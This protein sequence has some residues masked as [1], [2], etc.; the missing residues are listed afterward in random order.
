MLVIMTILI[1][2]I[3]WKFSPDLPGYLELKNYKPSLTTRVFTSDGKLLD[4]YFIE[5]RLFV[6]IEK[7]PKNL[8]N[9]FI[10]A[11]DKNYYSHVGFDIFSIIGA[12]LTNLSNLGSN[13]R[14]IGA[15]TITQQ[16]VKNF[17]LSKEISLER[18]IKEV[19][20]AI[21]IEQV[22]SKDSILELYL[23]DIYLGY[24]SY[25]VAASSLNY[26]NKPLQELNLEEMAYLA[27]LPKAPNNYHPTKNYNNAIERR[28]WVLNQMHLNG[29]ISDAELG[30][31]KKKL[32]VV[33]RESVHPINAKYFREEVR[34]VL[35]RNYGKKNLYEEGLIV[36]TTL[37]T[38]YQN[39][40]DQTLVNGLINHDK[41]RGW[42]G[43]ISN[44]DKNLSNE[45]AKDL[46]NIHNPF[47][48]IWHLVVVKEV[49]ARSMQVKYL[50]N[51]IDTI[52]LD[53]HNNW[54]E[55]ETFRI[56]DVFFVEK[57]S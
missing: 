33:K 15:S 3:L 52:I 45:N 44:V 55:N 4:K 49:Y 31:T 28:N 23:N 56:G 50:N 19:I 22:L 24:G 39:I 48:N 29:Y 17:L 43:P 53:E 34:K 1:F 11:E 54:L 20:L 9:A 6:P 51:E 14:L 42:R 10:S 38:F 32:I 12:T 18:K 21:R 37:D 7:I 36:K 2:Y 25:G 47:P 57:T 26:F 35:Y 5:E 46:I 27:A 16:V 41:R 13:K 30:V 8:I 40:A